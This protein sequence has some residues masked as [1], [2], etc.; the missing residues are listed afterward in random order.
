MQKCMQCHSTMKSDEQVCWACGAAAEPKEKKK[1]LRD[2]FKTVVNILFIVFA[3]LAVASIFTDYVP[4][5]WK[6]FG[7]LL[8]MYFVKNSIDQMVETTKKD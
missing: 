1:E 6:C 2:R 3:V 8:I 4:S 7:G 5:F